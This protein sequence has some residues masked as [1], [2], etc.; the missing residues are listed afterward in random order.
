MDLARNGGRIYLAT[1]PKLSDEDINAIS[2]GY[3]NRNE[4]ILDKFIQELKESLNEISDENAKLLEMLISSGILDIKVVL[5]NGGMYHDKLTLLE[6]F[7]NNKIAFVGS[8]NE[9]G[10]GY[11]GEDGNYEKVRIFKRETRPNVIV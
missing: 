10:P 8:P 3:I 7:S 4:L 1:S 6:D 2:L 5:K 9:S 11:D